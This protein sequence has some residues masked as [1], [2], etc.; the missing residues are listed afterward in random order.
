MQHYDAV[1][2]GGGILAI[3][4]IAIFF[5][6][7]PGAGYHYTADVTKWAFGIY[8]LLAGLLLAG[9]GVVAVG[10]LRSPETL[11]APAEAPTQPEVAVE[12]TVPQDWTVEDLPAP[13]EET[14]A[15]PQAVEEEIDE[16]L[17]ALETIQDS[18]D[19]RQEAPF[20]EGAAPPVQVPVT[21]APPAETAAQLAERLRTRR[22]LV[23]SYFL[24]P[25]LVDMAVIAV[26]AI[27]LPGADG[28]LQSYPQ[29]NTAALLAV[30]YGYPFIALYTVLSVYV[31]LRRA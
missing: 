10:S 14:P 4:V 17:A 5:A 27:F 25:A 30:A 2:V 19:E 13:L 6:G 15:E 28:L 29:L 12:D 24:G 9:I 18:M 11:A 16:L 7:G 26:S 3:A 22:A 20:V 8:A 1:I 23:A 21:A 31:I